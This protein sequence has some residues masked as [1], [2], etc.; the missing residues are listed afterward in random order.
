MELKKRDKEII[1]EALMLDIN[2]DIRDNAIAEFH[3]KMIIMLIN[4]RLGFGWNDDNIFTNFLVKY[5]KMDEIENGIETTNQDDIKQFINKHKKNLKIPTLWKYW[6]KGKITFNLPNGRFLVKDFYKHMREMIDLHN[7]EKFQLEL[8]NF[9]IGLIG[10][11]Q[12]DAIDDS[13]VRGDAPPGTHWVKGHW[14][15]NRTRTGA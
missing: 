14:R 5:A 9:Q 8:I 15:K 1:V 6:N 7:D 11:H 2:E 10:I 3:Q 13:D 12:K 4:T